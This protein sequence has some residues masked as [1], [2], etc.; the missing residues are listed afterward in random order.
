MP[1]KSND[2]PSLQLPETNSNNEGDCIQEGIVDVDQSSSTDIIK[3]ILSN[4]ATGGDERGQMVS[5]ET[6]NIVHRGQEEDSELLQSVTPI[7]ESNPKS[8]GST[9]KI[10]EKRKQL[11]DFLCLPSTE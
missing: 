8:T 1:P 3:N 10:D 11:E 2:E 6:S 4:S 7:A 5:L 9:P